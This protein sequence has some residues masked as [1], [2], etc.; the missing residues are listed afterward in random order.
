MPLLD[1]VEHLVK[2][3]A[4]QAVSNS[5]ILEQLEQQKET[6]ETQIQQAELIAEAEIDEKL[7]QEEERLL[8]KQEVE[9]LREWRVQVREEL[10]ELIEDQDDFYRATDVAIAIKGT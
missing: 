7:L 6:L 10:I 9:S 3:F 2:Q 4:Q 1:K 5:P 8:A